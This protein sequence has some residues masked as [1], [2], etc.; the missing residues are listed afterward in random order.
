MK[1]K[2]RGHNEGTIKQRKDGRWEAQVST[3]DGKRKSLYG[4]TRKEVQAKLTDAL[5]DVQQ[6]VSLPSGGQTMKK[7]VEQWLEQVVQPTLRPSTYRT[8]EQMSRNHIVPALGKLRVTDVTPQRII[9]F[10]NEK[11]ASGL[12]PRTIQY[13][14]AIIRQVLDQ[15]YRWNM[16]KE[17]AA[18]RVKTPRA[19]KYEA[20]TL[21]PEQARA[22]LDAVRGDRLEA[23]VT[24]ALSVGLRLGEALG[25]RWQDVDFD[26]GTLTIRH[27][28]QR[29]KVKDEQTGTRKGV[30][31]LVEPKTE[32]SRSTIPLPRTVVESLRQHRTRQLEERLAAG[33][34][35]QE[36]DLVFPTSRG[37]PMDG[38]NVTQRH[39]QGALRR[40]GLP[41]LRFHD[42]RHAAATLLLAQ[43]VPPRVV[44]ETLGHTDI[45]TT[46]HYQHVTQTL[47]REAADRME[48]AL[49]GTR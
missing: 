13:L 30:F 38:G 9:A 8:Y 19:A 40:A 21:D 11:R 4:K 20:P 3:S 37:T 10:L 35:W 48:A 44:M 12:S 33:S 36:R 45:R 7:L 15:A 41:E 1:G 29:V 42:L 49:F 27:Q 16:V 24:V 32:Q 18:K 31:M 43:G 2:H 46:T 23:L 28:L 14:H 22:V 6:G 39:F 34:R 25:L 26:A 5:L 17:N 47:Q